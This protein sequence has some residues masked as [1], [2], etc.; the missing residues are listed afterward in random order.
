MPIVGF[1]AVYSA[2]QPS[3]KTY[4][5]RLSRMRPVRVCGLGRVDD[6]EGRTLQRMPI[7]SRSDPLNMV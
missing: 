2:S 7:S 1:Y 4:L 3:S 6:E 5:T